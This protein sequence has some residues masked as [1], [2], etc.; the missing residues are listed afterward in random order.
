MIDD[1]ALVSGLIVRNEVL[2]VEKLLLALLD[3]KKIKLN[4]GV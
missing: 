3:G 2:T 1:G 4:N